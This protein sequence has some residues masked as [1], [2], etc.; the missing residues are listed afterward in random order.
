MRGAGLQRDIDGGTPN[1]IGCALA[2]VGQ[3]FD[4][5]MG[6]AR[7]PMVSSS[8]HPISHGNDGS[9]RRVGARQSNAAAGFLDGK[10]HEGVV[11]LGLGGGHGG[12]VA[13]CRCRINL[14]VQAF[15]DGG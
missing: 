1:L 15:E 11:G 9:N 12:R 3:G 5:G 14:R 13:S 10:G 7:F 8:D 2:G 4:L 6:T